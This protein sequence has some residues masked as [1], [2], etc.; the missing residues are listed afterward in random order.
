MQHIDKNT[1]IWQLT[2]EQ[3]VSCIKES[4]P[5]QNFSI[6][7]QE[8]TPEYI[9]GLKDLAKF[10]NISYS[11]T[12]RMKKQGIFDEAI[13][14]KERVIFINKKKVMEILKKQSEEK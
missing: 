8:D 2:V 5:P 12:W 4:F 9:T 6:G 14:Q 10:L 3:L 13:I 7:N 11:Q 1:P